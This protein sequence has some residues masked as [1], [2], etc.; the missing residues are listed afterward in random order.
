MPKPSSERSPEFN[1][2]STYFTD[3]NLP[4]AGS[5]NLDLELY[6]LPLTFFKSEFISLIR[7]WS[8]VLTA[9]CNSKFSS[10]ILFWSPSKYLKPWL[11]TLSCKVL[12][13]FR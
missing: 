7:S 12:K 1:S 5:Y 11:S 4:V 9:F 6:W 2:P 13:H 3:T 10:A 8:P